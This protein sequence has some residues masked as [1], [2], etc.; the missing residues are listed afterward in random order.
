MPFTWSQ[1]HAKAN[2]GPHNWPHHHHGDGDPQ[3]HLREK[4]E[5]SVSQYLLGTQ[6]SK[7]V[8]LVGFG[9]ASSQLVQ[10]S[11]I[12]AVVFVFVAN[13]L[14]KL[15]FLKCQRMNQQCSRICVAQDYQ[16]G[17]N[18]SPKSKLNEN[19]IQI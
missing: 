17:Q 7:V 10:V 5:S 14:T 8:E 11:Q 12:P 4:P 1:P 3:P 18:V 13:T 15:R 16:T 6:P 2:N 9:L 19:S